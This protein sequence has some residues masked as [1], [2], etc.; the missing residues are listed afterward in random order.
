MALRTSF[1]RRIA[2]A[3]TTLAVVGCSALQIDVD[4]YKG[5]LVNR[6]DV[7]VRQ[8][9]YLVSASEPL[10]WRKRLR[11]VGLV[12]DPVSQGLGPSWSIQVSPLPQQ[13]PG[14][15][16]AYLLRAEKRSLPLTP[17]RRRALQLAPAA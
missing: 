13:G 16:A 11:A 3:L 7:Q 2:L 1:A 6:L 9:A 15:R 4:V 10:V 17:V 12:P 5:P 8:Y 14:L